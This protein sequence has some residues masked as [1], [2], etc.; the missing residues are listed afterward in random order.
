M[1][2]DPYLPYYGPLQPTAPDGEGLSALGNLVL[3]QALRT[4]GP[5]LVI[6]QSNAGYDCE[7]ADEGDD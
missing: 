3:L 4:P 7:E 6:E 5:P 2:V 1:F